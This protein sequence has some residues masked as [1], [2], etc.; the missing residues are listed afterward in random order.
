MVLLQS[1]LREAAAVGREA[2][3]KEDDS[4]PPMTSE[5][6]EETHECDCQLKIPHFLA[7]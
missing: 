4:T 1:V 3:P 7:L 6:G 5:R 2:I